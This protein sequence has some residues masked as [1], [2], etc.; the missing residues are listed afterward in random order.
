MIKSLDRNKYH[1]RD[2]ISIKMIKMC[3]ESLAL[4]LN[5]IFQTALND[6]VIPN[7][8]K[9]GNIVPV[10]KKDLKIMLI[11][12]RPISLLSIFAKIFEKILFTSRFDHF[13][14]NELF[15]VCQIGFFLGDSR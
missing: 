13:A 6:G 8:W 1:E 7:E 11:N 12:Y 4:R 10:Q 14:E 2:N 9:K 3:G 5:I 15:T